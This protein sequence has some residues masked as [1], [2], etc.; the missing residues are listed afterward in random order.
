MLEYSNNESS[1]FNHNIFGKKLKKCSTNPLTG[2]FRDGS[3]SSDHRDKGNHSVCAIVSDAFLEYTKKLGNDLSTPNHAY[4]FPGLKHGDQ[5]CLCATRWLE[6]Y[7]AGI[8]LKVDLNA[9]HKRALEVLSKEQ[10]N[11]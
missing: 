10:L 4:N 11:F 6:A 5:W 1:S 7:N 9:T 8:K 3:C 2:F